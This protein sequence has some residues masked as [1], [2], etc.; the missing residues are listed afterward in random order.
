MVAVI[1][2]YD[3]QKR[4]LLQ[5]RD[6]KSARLPGYWAF[7]GGEIK[8]GESPKDAVI[9]E[10]FEELHYQL[11]SPVQR[12]NQKISWEEIRGTMHVF[13]EEYDPSQEITLREGKGM[14]WFSIPETITL[15]MVD[16]D[17]EVLKSLDGTF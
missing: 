6:D 5:H 4:I 2:L 12:A 17:R 15:K 3:A 8:K 10:T 13:M 16:Y 1:L 7:F 9:R 14:G 11:K